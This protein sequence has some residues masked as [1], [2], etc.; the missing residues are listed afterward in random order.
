M[1]DE[2]IAGSRARSGPSLLIP[3][4]RR[5]TLIPLLLIPALCL[6]V[7]SRVSARETQN[8]ELVQ[9]GCPGGVASAETAGPASRPV[10]T[11]T[12]LVDPAAVSKQGQ[13]H[14]ETSALDDQ[15]TRRADESPSK[16][17][18]DG[19]P[20]LVRAPHGPVGKGVES[21]DG[22]VRRSAADL[23]NVEQSFRTVGVPAEAWW[24]GPMLAASADTLSRGHVLLEPYLFDSVSSHADHFGSVVYALYGVTDRFSAGLMPVFAY[25]SVRGG[26]HSSA[27]QMGDLTIILQY[28]FF[29]S[30]PGSALPTA[31]VVVEEI[32]PTGRYDRLDARYDDG[33]GSGAYATSVGIYLQFR[34]GLENG[35][36]LRARLDVS[37]V[38]SGGADVSGLSVYGTPASF[39]GRAEPGGTSVV[40]GALEYS[41]STRWALATD[42]VFQRSA[43]TSIEVPSRVPVDGGAGSILSRLDPS[44]SVGFAPAIEYSW[45]AARGVL[46][47]ARI[48]PANR[49]TPMAVSTVVAFNCVF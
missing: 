26:R 10:Q 29:K 30:A 20:S 28:R 40:I 22:D 1:R 39:R 47:G 2:A 43:S 25:T 27:P 6:Q 37:H 8:S 42:V 12:A 21:R 17:G 35:H 49:T 5:G 23:T 48:T 15:C 46:L 32:L 18:T 14:V 41:L 13:S 44:G 7:A 4:D 11:G 33:F 16:A 34:F 31:S 9:H 36:A 3:G 19:T 38:F 24:T 45:S